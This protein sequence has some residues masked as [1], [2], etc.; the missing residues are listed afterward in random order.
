M[1]E[2]VSVAVV[3]RQFAADLSFL[4]ELGDRIRVLDGN[5]ASTLDGALAEA[6][7]LLLGFPVPSVIAA[8]APR[9]RWAHQ[10]QAGVSNL[11]HSDLWRSDVVLTSSRG[12]VGT[13]P[14]AE[15]A[16]AGIFHFARG[17]DTALVHKHEGRLGRDGYELRLVR[18]ATLGVVGLG[19]IGREVARLGRA[20]GMRVVATR[21]SVTATQHDVEG[22]DTLLPAAELHTLAAQSDY[23]VLCAQLTDETRHLIDA[24]VFAAMKPG[25]VFVNI[26]RGEEV[27]ED[28][29]IDALRAGRLRGAL[30]DVYEGELAGQPPRSELIEMPGVVLTPHLSPS[31][32]ADLWPPVKALF[33]EN[34]RRYLDGE[35][36]LNVVDRSRGY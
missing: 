7:V 31:S 35:E 8:R 16:I 27:D 34:L 24:G 14:I 9:L 11:F 15:Y 17:L 19:G 25:A 10:T 21:R 36:L 30:L 12:A 18:G 2:P 26:A 3:A 13:T 20:V 1:T 22:V 23:V 33:V 4:D 28:A 29:L 6:E 32:D 5:D